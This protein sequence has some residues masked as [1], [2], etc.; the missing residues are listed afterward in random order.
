MPHAGG[1]SGPAGESGVGTTALARLKMLVRHG[2]GVE[3]VTRERRFGDAVTAR[4]WAQTQVRDA[5]PD[6]EIREIVIETERWNSPRLWQHAGTRR[7]TILVQVGRTHQPEGIVWSE[8]LP[9]SPRP[10][11]RHAR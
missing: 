9:A 11:A 3:E 1:E 2:V 6:A 8:P 10:G 7:R 5:D 4:E